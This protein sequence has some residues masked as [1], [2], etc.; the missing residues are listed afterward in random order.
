MTCPVV[1]DRNYSEATWH[2]SEPAAT[3][4]NT[5]VTKTLWPTEDCPITTHARTKSPFENT[6][7][8]SIYSRCVEA[9]LL[10]RTT[11]VPLLSFLNIVVMVSLLVL[12]RSQKDTINNHERMNHHLASTTHNELMPSLLSF[13]PPWR[14]GCKRWISRLPT[15][16][17]RFVGLTACPPLTAHWDARDGHPCDCQRRGG[18]NLNLN[19][20]SFDYD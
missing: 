10:S 4:S 13:P 2:R 17:P 20:D 9:S 1:W 14:P 3:T 15:S 11:D 19:L 8:T 7:S 12:K 5:C 6:L 16:R 18:L